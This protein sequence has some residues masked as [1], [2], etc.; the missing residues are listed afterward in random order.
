[1]EK[2]KKKK[3]K[4]EKKKEKKL[5]NSH[6]TQKTHYDVVQS[7]I[8]PT[9][10]WYKH[11]FLP[12]QYISPIN[13][14]II[15]LIFLQHIRCSINMT[16]VGKNIIQQYYIPINN[17]EPI[18]RCPKPSSC[19]KFSIKLNLGNNFHSNTVWYYIDYSI[20][21]YHSIPITSLI[22]PPLLINN[23]IITIFASHLIF[24]T[25]QFCITLASNFSRG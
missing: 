4:N 1:M 19:C 2:K 3:K 14:L 6:Y 18:W 11:K 17:T 5:F 24:F 9:Q 15:I 13:T 10:S 12:P 22:I 25:I 20:I 23:T 16:V 7:I 8:I 21:P